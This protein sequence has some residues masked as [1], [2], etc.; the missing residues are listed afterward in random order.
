M[1][2]MA[3]PRTVIRF[4][5]AASN[6]PRTSTAAAAIAHFPRARPTIRKNAVS[7]PEL[8]SNAT[9]ADRAT[10]VSRRRRFRSAQNSAAVW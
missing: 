4:K 3:L 10:S 1:D 2:S 5:D 9:A 6:P 8:V 7:C